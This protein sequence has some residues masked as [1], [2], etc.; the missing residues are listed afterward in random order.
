MF[1]IVVL[2]SEYPVTKSFNAQGEKEKAP[3]FSTGIAVKL[4]VKDMNDLEDTYKQLSQ[5]NA[6]CYGTVDIGHNESVNVGLD[7][8][9]EKNPDLPPGWIARTLDYF[10]YAAGPGIL[11]VDYDAGGKDSHPQ[12]SATQFLGEIY[13]AVPKLAQAPQLCKP[14]AGSYIWDIANE[15]WLVED[16]GHHAYFLIDDQR[17][18]KAIIDL[19]RKSFP[20]DAT[21]QPNRLDYQSVWFQ[22]DAMELYEKREPDYIIL[23]NDAD[24]FIAKDFS[25]GSREGE[26]TSKHSAVLL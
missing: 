3:N 14:S 8:T 5:F 16:K 11:F 25:D 6:I 18:C 9:R 21:A 15:K 20:V 4:E 13:K 2:K 23:N 1:D 17:K 19:I 10:N 24:P 7:P 26:A 22:K 12:I